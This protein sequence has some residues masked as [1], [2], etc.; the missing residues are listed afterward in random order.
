MTT[1]T[2]SMITTPPIAIPADMATQISTFQEQVDTLQL[3]LAAWAE[4]AARDQA[5]HT[6]HTR[7][8]VWGLLSAH[9]LTERTTMM[10]DARYAQRQA[11]DRAT[12]ALRDR[13]RAEAELHDL[14]LLLGAPT[15]GPLARRL[16]VAREVWALAWNTRE[17]LS[18][19]G[20]IGFD[21]AAAQLDILLENKE[22][23]GRPASYATPDGGPIPA[24][25]LARPR[26]LLADGLLGRMVHATRRNAAHAGLGSAAAIATPWDD[27]SQ[28]ERALCEWIGQ[29]LLIAGAGGV[30][31]RAYA[32]EGALDDVAWLLR[33]QPGDGTALAL[34]RID[35]CLAGD[36]VAH[37]AR[38][39]R[40][41]LQAVAAAAATLRAGIDDSTHKIIWLRTSG[42]PIA[43]LDYAMHA[44][45][46]A[47]EGAD[48]R[49]DTELE[50]GISLALASLAKGEHELGAAVLT[51]LLGA[52]AGALLADRVAALLAEQSHAQPA[53]GY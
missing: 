36:T 13:D 8:L 25:E 18:I 35:A 37:A 22:W 40:R 28:D 32:L 41:A 9:E 51:V 52:P 53:G 33:E 14:K 47:A 21:A 17:V 11:E 19:G 44:S 43:A 1:E 12:E 29:T 3:Q 39:P 2:S 46:L 45:M 10:V 50:H 38:A 6:A 34:A 42:G 4:A 23:N 5:E 30:S 48:S 15:T 26:A 31:Q 20:R 7:K 49:T 24:A 27:V 16:A